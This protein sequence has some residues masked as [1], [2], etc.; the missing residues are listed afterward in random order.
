MRHYLFI[1]LIL[2][3][4]SCGQSENPVQE[5]ISYKWQPFDIKDVKLLDGP[6]RHAMELN[7][8]IL[9][10]YEPDRFLSNFRKEANLKPK[11]PHYEGWE[12]ETISGHSLGHYLSACALMYAST[13]DSL[14][15]QRV[16]YIVQELGICQEAD[17]EG[18]IGAFP[19]G[20][21]ILEDEVAVGNIRSQGFDLNGIWVPYYNEHKTLAGLRDAYRLCGNEQAL[22]IASKLADWLYTIVDDLSDDQVQTMLKCEFGGIQETFSDLY[23]DTGNEKYLRLARIFHHKEIIDPLAEGIDIL[24]GKHGNTQ[25]PKIIASA[26]IYELTEDTLE[27]NA[28]AFFWDRVVNHHSY[29][30]GGHG[31]FEYFGEPDH[32]RNR[33]SDGTTESCNV[34]N[35]L[36]LSSHLL[37]WDAEAGTADF[38]ERAL[39]NHILSAQHPETGYVIYNLSLEMG[40]R[41]EYQDPYWFTCCIGTGM[42]THS[43]HGANIYYRNDQEIVVSQ[44]IASEL[45][46]RA[47]GVKII[48]NT[49]FPEE[50]GTT[51]TVKTLENKNFTLKIRYPFWAT[52]GY[53]VNVNDE[54]MDII[55]QPG[56]FISITR[57]WSDN[58]RVTVEFP[59]SL[60]LESMPDDQDRIAVFYG[61][62]L[63]AGDIGPD[64]MPISYEP[65]FVPVLMSESREPMEWLVREGDEPNT[66]R[67]NDIGNPRDLVMKPFYKIHNRRYSVYFDLFTAEKWEEHQAEYMAQQLA[68]SALEKRTYDFFQAGEMQPER[69]HGFEGD[70]LEIVDFR[71]RKGRLAHRGGRFSFT[72]NVLPGE[73]MSL[74]VEYWGGYTGSKTFDILVEGEKIATE[75]ISGKADGKFID[76]PY[77]IPFQL[78]EGKKSVSIEFIPHTGHRAGPVFG[79]RSVRR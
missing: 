25:I 48:Q 61:P 66:F 18:F 68:R 7:R 15:L 33:L 20:K 60:R 65:G 10:Q 11:A 70:S 63:L 58:D 38:Y 57:L 37:S 72:M 78:T 21:R 24:P 26:R 27:R 16:N 32:L 79:V 51:L 1:I 45:N 55:P 28:A 41:K 44:F 22:E 50:Q 54:P 74:V 64:D 76:V 77:E 3:M 52:E 9:L 56:S 5:K 2:V 4:G 42:E 71:N 40:G 30:T 67:M 31:N 29:V 49:S 17:G 8:R 6:L 53:R 47:K 39:F 43:Q 34:Y 69:D 19:N 59:F 73:P 13:G 46:D 62:L 36:K 12:A 35:M 14:F 23:A 75:N